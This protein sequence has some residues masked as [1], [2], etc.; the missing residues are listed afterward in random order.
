MQRAA[1]ETKVFCCVV[2]VRDPP[3]GPDPFPLWR[4]TFP[5]GFHIQHLPCLPPPYYPPTPK[6]R[7]LLDWFSSIKGIHTHLLRGLEV[8]IQTETRYHDLKGLQPASDSQ[9]NK[10]EEEWSFLHFL[11]KLRREEKMNSSYP[12]SS[13]QGKKYEILSLECLLKA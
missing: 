12:A 5:G 6:T 2:C 3:F 10:V 9:Y 8:T 11:R 7:E 1:M 13:Y 4:H